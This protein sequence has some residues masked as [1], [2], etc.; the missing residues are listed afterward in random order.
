MNVECGIMNVELVAL[1]AIK[2]YEF[3]KV[4]Q[5]NLFEILKR[6]KCV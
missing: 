6:R 1:R 4:S 5:M 3:T 2:N